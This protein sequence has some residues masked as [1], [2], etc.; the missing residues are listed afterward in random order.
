MKTLRLPVLCFLLVSLLPTGLYATHFQGAALRYDCLSG[1][2]TYRIWVTEYFDC[3]GLIPGLPPTLTG[4]VSLNGGSC[5]PVPLGGWQLASTQEVTPLCPSLL[6][7]LGSNCDPSSAQGFSGSQERV[8]FRD[9][10]LC[11][12]GCTQVSVTYAHCCRGNDETNIPPASEVYLAMEVN[13]NTCNQA[14][15]FLDPGA[16]LLSVGQ[17][18]QISLAAFDPDGDSLHYALVACQ[19]SGGQN[20]VFQPGFSLTDPLGGS[21]TASLDAATGDLTLLPTPGQALS[22]TLCVEVAEY[23]QGTLLGTHV[24]DF[25]LVVVAPSG[26]FTNQPPSLQLGNPTGGLALGGQVFR[27]FA[28]LPFSLPLSATDP[29]GDTLT[30]R[31][32]QNLPGASLMDGLGPQDSLTGLA[33]AGFWQWTPPAPGHY[34]LQVE[35]EDA[36]CWLQG[37]AET[38]LVIQVDTCPFTLDLGP[39]TTLCPGD[40]LVLGNPALPGYSYQWNLNPGLPGSSLTLAQPTFYT[41]L[42]NQPGTIPVTLTMT[43][44]NGCSRTDT[45]HISY[46]ASPSTSFIATYAVCQGDTA[47]LELAGNLPPGTA[48]TWDFDSAIVVS[49]NGAG[50][51]QLIWTQ[52]GHYLPQVSFAFSGCPYT[53]STQ[54]VVG[55]PC[56]W[57]GDANYDGIADHFDLLALGFAYGDSGLPRFQPSLLWDAQPAFPWGD[58]LPSGLDKVHC[59]TDG[60]GYVTGDDTLAIGLNYGLV[61]NK[62][63]DT[64]GGPGDPPLLILPQVDTTQVGDT[65][66]LP[67]ILGVDTLPADSIYGLAFTVTYDPSLVDT[68][69]GLRISY[70][71]SWL[72]DR[73]VDMLTLSYSLPAEGR[74]DVALTRTDHLPR[75]GH[76]TIAVMTIVM[77]DDIAGKVDLAETLPLDLVNVRA[78][79][80]SGQALPLNPGSAAVV[81]TQTTT[82]LA[83]AWDASLRV[84]PQPAR[85]YLHIHLN[86]PGTWETTLFTLTG[87]V[88]RQ[89]PATHPTTDLP[90]TGIAPGLY[91][92]R[93]T[94]AG[95][96]AYRRV[97][98]K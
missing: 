24:L 44:P 10:D 19:G 68:A 18:A 84:Y 92:L 27:A 52:A 34:S 97:L 20:L 77:V 69:A 95:R 80:A 36:P 78:L 60:D 46:P 9:Y 41:P 75:S 14:P 51:Y 8:F 29:E 2:C 12:S 15:R 21:W 71:A 6:A 65:L 33:P 31:W 73:G 91:L 96:H 47:S 39:D 56:V 1:G 54:M 81:V 23:R 74:F 32:S 59:D 89:Q 72:G 48:F 83:P 88:L 58:S 93:V 42:S 79:G 55:E 43:A 67:I 57:P 61:H 28:G 45:L 63:D 86:Q 3:G 53:R 17:P 11:S 30:L 37:L 22:A 49:G 16:I 94:Y 35:V 25:S 40:T 82:G 13:L 90:L 7:S 5:S 70:P 62:R 26:G 64:R 87:Q 66:S 98:V 76:G 50:P 4:L 85:D 38:G